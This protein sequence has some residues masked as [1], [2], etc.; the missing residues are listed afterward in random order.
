MLSSI[1]KKTLCKTTR[2]CDWVPGSGLIQE[3][4]AGLAR[5]L[6]DL[7]LAAISCR[8]R[9]GSKALQGPARPC[10]A[11]QGPARPCK[12]L[13]GSES[14]RV[15]SQRGSKACLKGVAGHWPTPCALVG[16]C[17]ICSGEK[18]CLQ[19]PNLAQRKMQRKNTTSCCYEADCSGNRT[20][21]D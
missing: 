20:S 16:R 4:C 10:K 18:P 1:W 14:L 15:P 6:H 11:L 13:Q 8:S 12:A 5:R 2:D 3:A 19:A 17:N 21:S 7:L 9:N